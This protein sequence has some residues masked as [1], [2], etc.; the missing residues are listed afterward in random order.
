MTLIPK[1]LI[2]PDPFVIKEGALG[3][4]DKCGIELEALGYQLELDRV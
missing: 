3:N 2:G 1:F 4:F